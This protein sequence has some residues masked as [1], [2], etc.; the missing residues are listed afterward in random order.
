MCIYGSIDTQRY[1]LDLSV[2]IGVQ[3]SKTKVSAQDIWSNKDKTK[4]PPNVISI[5]CGWQ[6][7]KEIDSHILSYIWIEQDAYGTR[8]ERAAGFFVWHCLKVY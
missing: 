7:N 8:Y 3:E 6:K 2:F 1:I 4:Y 5:F